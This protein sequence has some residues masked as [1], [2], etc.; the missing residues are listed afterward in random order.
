M[1]LFPEFQPMLN[2]ILRLALVPVLLTFLLA[3][4]DA[5]ITQPRILS[6]SPDRYANLTEQL[7]NRL[8]AFDQEKRS[9]IAFV[10]AKVREGKLEARLVL[11]AQRYAIRRNS[12]FPFPFFERALRVEA[13][14]RGVALPTVR[15]FASTRGSRLPTTP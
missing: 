7:T 12:E 3:P 15:Q 13:G 2:S 6:A 4:V 8:R 14:K 10:V 9:Y 5:Q 11:A 1:S